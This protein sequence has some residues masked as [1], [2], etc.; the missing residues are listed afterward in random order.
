MTL[1]HVHMIVVT[2]PSDGSPTG[3]LSDG[4]LVNALLD[5]DGEDRSLGE[6][7]D[8]EVNTISSSEPL[9]AA[10]ELMRERRIAHLLVRDAH[11]GKPA[12]M[13][14]TLDVAGVLA[15]GEG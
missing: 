1:H 11:S 6:V 2:D 12:G 13:L 7:A 9:G 8:G 4:A 14:S 10:A 15:W 5:L 3:L